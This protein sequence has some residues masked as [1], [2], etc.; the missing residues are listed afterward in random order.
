VANI[1]I[2]DV[3][4]TWAEVLRQRASRNHRSLQ[5][6]LMALLERAVSETADHP[7]ALHPAPRSD[8]RT[9]T[10]PKTLGWKTIEQLAQ[11]IRSH[12]P[13]GLP[14]GPSSID[15]VREDRDAR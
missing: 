7:T 9:T 10:A 11:D 6:E 4:E 15:L 8:F 2:K 13:A 1:S 14:S 12:H 3:P 5:G